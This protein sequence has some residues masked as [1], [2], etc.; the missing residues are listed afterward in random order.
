[1]P[2]KS[3]G[4]NRQHT[5]EQQ[6]AKRTTNQRG[7]DYEHQTNR[8]R[9]LTR[10]TDGKRCWWCGHPM[11]KDAARNWDRKA[12]HAEHSKSQAKHGIG[13]TRADRLMHDTCN[14]QRGDGS[15]DDQRPVL[16]AQQ[17]LEDETE[18]AGLG[19]LVMGWPTWAT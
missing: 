9:L 7:Y 16:L 3:G 8:T 10:H 17:T 1:M 12:L 4:S 19:P 11:F 13:R 5:R 6:R 15:R 2:S 14:K 18:D